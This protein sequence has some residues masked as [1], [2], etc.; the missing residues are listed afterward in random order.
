MV[1]SAGYQDGYKCHPPG[2]RGKAVGQDWK[3]RWDMWLPGFLR[4]FGFSLHFRGIISSVPAF[5]LERGV[6]GRSY[7]CCWIGGSA[8]ENRFR[9]ALVGQITDKIT[10][11]VEFGETETLIFIIHHR[12]RAAATPSIIVVGHALAVLELHV[13]FDN[14]VRRFRPERCAPHGLDRVQRSVVKGQ[15]WV[16]RGERE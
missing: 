2:L 13:S 8:D 12:R 6:G 14:V 15:G 9:Q 16:C 1:Y 3:V 11:T 7:S 5:H 10:G 4:G